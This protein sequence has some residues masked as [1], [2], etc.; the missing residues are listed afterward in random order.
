MG[1]ASQ[2][3]GILVRIHIQIQFFLRC[4]NQFDRPNPT[5]WHLLRVDQICL[6]P[7]TTWP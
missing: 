3:Y 2:S 7:S 6:A 5:T 4:T 1:A